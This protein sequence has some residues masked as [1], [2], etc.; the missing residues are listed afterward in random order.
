MRVYLGPYND[1]N[2]IQQFLN[3][4]GFY[5]LS[6]LFQRTRKEKIKIHPYDAWNADHTLSLIIVPVLEQLKAV[7]QGH[8]LLDVEDFPEEMKLVHETWSDYTPEQY[9]AMSQAWNLILDK[10]IWSHKQI[11]KNDDWDDFYITD[12]NKQVVE[13]EVDFKDA[14]FEITGKRTHPVM[15]WD[16]RAAYEERIREGLLLFGKYYQALWD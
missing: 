1:L 3:C 6:K 2:W 5:K 10:M 9:E 4:R 13:E 15:N 16:A 8:P 11:A 12:D 7:K 14:L